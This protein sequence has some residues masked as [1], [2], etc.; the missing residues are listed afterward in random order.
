[1]RTTFKLFCELMFEKIKETALPIKNPWI[2]VGL[3]CLAVYVYVIAGSITQPFATDEMYNAGWAHGV[4]ETGNPAYYSGEDVRLLHRLKEP[5]SHPPLHVNLLAI[6]ILIFGMKY[7]ALRL[8][9]VIFFAISIWFL[10]YR[11]LRHVQ[12]P[13]EQLVLTAAFLI[14]NPMFVQESIVLAIEAQAFWFPMLLFFYWFYKESVQTAKIRIYPYLWSTLG[15]FILLWLKE[16]NFPIYMAF[17]LM[18]LIITRKFIR[19]P[20]FILTGIMAVTLFWGSWLLYCQIT[21][22]EVWS[23]WDFTVK[24]KMLDGAGGLHHTIKKHGWDEA[25][26][27][28]LSSLRITTIWS[29]LP[30]VLLFGT[31][32]VVRLRD[33]ILRRKPIAFMEMLALYSLVLFGVTKVLRP[34]DAFIKYEVPGHFLAA[35]FMADVYIELLKKEVRTVLFILC[36]GIVVALGIWHDIPDRILHHRDAFPAHVTYSLLIAG[37]TGAGFWLLQKKQ[38]VASI[39][40]GLLLAVFML[41]SVLYIH[42]SV[43]TYTTGQSWGNYGEDLVPVTRWLRENLKNGETFAAFKDLQFNIRFV[44]GK[45]KSPTYEARTFIKRNKSRK[46]R[47]SKTKRAEILNRGDIRFFVLNRYSDDESGIRYLEKYGYRKIRRLKE[48]LIYEKKPPAVPSEVKPEAKP[49]VKTDKPVASP[50]KKEGQG[51]TRTVQPQ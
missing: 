48:H 46:W 15:I 42:Q 9:G 27:E 45:D 39:S 47:T 18:F 34:T 21:G 1:M 35:I 3:I 2:W 23:W 50:P 29:S 22:A 44:E 14:F 11:V 40:L 8:L 41:N 20:A 30:Y 4:S 28:V 7:W 51:V 19:I 17:C 5:V 6:M 24:G 12:M 13:H 43:N 49:K 32:I 16:T 33:V 37:F 26:A 25:I 31:A 10:K 38:F 36:A